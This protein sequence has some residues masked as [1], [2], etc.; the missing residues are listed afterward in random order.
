MPPTVSIT[1]ES[2][3][4]AM[5]LARNLYYFFHESGSAAQ[6]PVILLHGMAADCLSW[7]PEIRRLPG[8]NVLALDL[9]G[10]GKSGGVACQ[11]VEEYARAVLD[12]MDGLGIWSAVFVGHSLGAAIALT[13]AQQEPQRTAGLVLVSVGSRLTLPETLSELAASDSTFLIAVKRLHTLLCGP[14]TPFSLAQALLRQLETT[15]SSLLYSD[16]VACTTFEAGDDLS[17]LQSLALVV[18]GTE[19]R[20]V[21]LRQASWLAASLPEAALQTVDGASHLLPLEQPG[22]LAR[23]LS[24]FLDTLSPNPVNS[25][26]NPRTEPAKWDG[27][28]SA[29]AL[30]G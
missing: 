11:S 27:L 7:P 17:L 26:P 1:V 2:N 28:A 5:P 4:D 21:P 9:P 30:D 29:P 14:Q 20:V 23:L 22:R 13:L 24:V 3:R 8:R 25:H 10:H 16:L 12:W 6:P 18:I 19:D 15:R